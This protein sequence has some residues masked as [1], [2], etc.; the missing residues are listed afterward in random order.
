MSTGLRHR[1]EML[2]Q[3]AGR[4]AVT[5]HMPSGEVRFVRGDQRHWVALYQAWTE[6]MQAELEEL[7]E[8]ASAL[9]SELNAI[10]DALKI[11]E[12][13]GRFGLFA[14]LMQGPN[15]EGEESECELTPQS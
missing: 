1:V 8:P 5:L 12:D 13:G 10:R 2:E 15:C 9:S 3:R 6:R 11:D 7:S 4:A 14:I